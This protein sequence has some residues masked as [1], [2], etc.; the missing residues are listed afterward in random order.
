MGSVDEKWRRDSSGYKLLSRLV[1]RSWVLN[2]SRMQ[3]SIKVGV[4]E[5]KKLSW[6][7]HQRNRCSFGNFE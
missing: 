7:K 2:I 5:V 4:C 3:L 6:S 1:G